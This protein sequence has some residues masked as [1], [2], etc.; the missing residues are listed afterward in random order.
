MPKPSPVITCKTA[1]ERSMTKIIHQ[2][3][4][5]NLSCLAVIQKKHRYLVCL[6]VSATVRSEHSYLDIHRGCN[7]SFLPSSWN[8]RIMA[9]L[10]CIYNILSYMHKSCMPKIGRAKSCW[11]SAD[12]NLFDNSRRRSILR[13]SANSREYHCW[14]SRDLWKRPGRGQWPTQTRHKASATP[15]VKPADLWWFL[16]SLRQLLTLK[17]SARLKANL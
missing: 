9:N 12:K 15:G 1:I 16:A 7:P 6:P 8:N 5:W 10:Y 17:Q 11:N 4:E 3:Y 14:R 13:G 2:K